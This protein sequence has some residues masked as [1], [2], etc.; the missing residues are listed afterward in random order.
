MTKKHKFG[1]VFDRM[2]RLVSQYFCNH[3]I[4]EKDMEHY[5][6]AKWKA[7]CSKCGKM[8]YHTELHS[9]PPKHGW[10]TSEG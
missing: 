1:R 2:K 6:Y 7:P 3:Q 8:F 9:L 4:L 5:D 10:N